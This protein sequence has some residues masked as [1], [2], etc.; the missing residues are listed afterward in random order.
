MTP[1]YCPLLAE[2]GYLYGVTGF[3]GAYGY[4]VIYKHTTTP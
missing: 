3:G 2:D 1:S 4:G